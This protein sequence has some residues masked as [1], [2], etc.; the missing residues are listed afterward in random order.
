MDKT[1]DGLIDDEEKRV[2]G[3]EDPDGE[4]DSTSDSC[5]P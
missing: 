2:G 3:E 4:S 5:I 1:F